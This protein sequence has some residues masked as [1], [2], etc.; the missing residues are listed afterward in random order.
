M[1]RGRWSPAPVGHRR[2]CPDGCRCGD[3]GHPASG[4]QNESVAHQFA[5]LSAGR[6]HAASR[7]R[8][9]RIEMPDSIGSSGL[10]GERRR[11][12]RKLLYLI[13]RAPDGRLCACA[14]TG[15]SRSSFRPQLGPRRDRARGSS[16]GAHATPR[17]QQK[18]PLIFEAAGG[19]PGIEVEDQRQQ[20]PRHRSHRSRPPQVA[21]PIAAQFGDRCQPAPSMTELLWICYCSLGR[22]PWSPETVH[23]FT[24]ESVTYGVCPQGVHRFPPVPPRPTTEVT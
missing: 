17:L 24:P 16:P 15:H 4:H 1:E 10:R 2:V 13:G 6:R 5:A 12:R 20:A 14:S 22:C 9:R 21:F 23:H 19:A 3:A 7:R 11:P 8:R 18:V